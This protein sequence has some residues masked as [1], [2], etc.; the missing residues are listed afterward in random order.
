MT[1]TQSLQSTNNIE[2][3]RPKWHFAGE[4]RLTFLLGLL[5][6]ICAVIVFGFRV[7]ASLKLFYFVDETEK[8]VAARM[9]NQGLHLYKDVFAHHG[10]VTYML[11]HLYAKV[12]SQTDFSLIRL[13]IVFLAAVSCLS[14]AFSPILKCITARIWAAALYLSILSSVWALQAI[15]MLL[16]SQIGGFLFVIV[17]S[18][19]V[20]P[21]LMGEKPTSIG[22][23]ISGFSITLAFFS[24]YSFGP[25]AVFF[26][27]ST[28]LSLIDQKIKTKTS[29][30]FFLGIFSALTIVILWLVLFGDLLG[31]LIYHIY[32]NQKIYAPFIEFSLLSIFSNF[33]ISF[34]P[35]NLIHTLAVLFLFAWTFALAITVIDNKEKGKSLV[36]KIG[37]IA[38]LFVAVLFANPR[39]EHSYQNA[40]F[41]VLNF[42]SISLVAAWLLQS[43]LRRL[44]WHKM[45]YPILF[46]AIFTFSEG[47]R[48]YSISTPHGFA[49][50]DFLSNEVDFKPEVGGIYDFIRSITR[51]DQK[52]LALIFE[53]IIYIK[54][55]RLPASGHYYYLPWQAAYN[56]ASIF[57]YKIDICKDII[58][59]KPNIIFFDDYKLWNKY[60]IEQY[61]PCV[62]SLIDRNYVR[63]KSRDLFIRK[64]IALNLT[65]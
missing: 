36:F 58:D 32:F 44:S 25:A 18:Q 12:V 4:K 22:L 29:V 14:L 39:G 31:Y 61:E 65:K 35:T 50:K 42:A 60:S 49:K 7:N 51:P 64:D 55:D 8:F 2:P 43:Q 59:Q 54:A 16:Y 34:L 30:L 9:I 56:R 23:F 6:L 53:P 11:A 19:L 33:N 38:S 28:F 20:I 41:V 24:A 27:A 63:F 52:I 21:V 62:C 17:L 46:M 45:I 40:G 47:V 5:A 57:D 1:Q 15:H 3:L 37:A 10:P 48:A 13:E 26:V